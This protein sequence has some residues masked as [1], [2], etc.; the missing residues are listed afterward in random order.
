MTE[1]QSK[2]WNMAGD[3]FRRSMLAQYGSFAG[4]ITAGTPG[5]FT[6][7]GATQLQAELGYGPSTPPAT[8]DIT[9]PSSPAV[10]A[11]YTTSPAISDVKVAAVAAAP[12]DIQVMAATQ[13]VGGLLSLSETTGIPLSDLVQQVKA[14]PVYTPTGQYTSEEKQVAFEQEFQQTYGETTSGQPVI[15]SGAILLLGALVLLG[16]S[17]W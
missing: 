3:A 1:E 2:F 14:Q 4:W 17:R 9:M 5:Y 10:E 12:T 15:S 11:F 13:Q 7:W 6:G 8:I 16:G